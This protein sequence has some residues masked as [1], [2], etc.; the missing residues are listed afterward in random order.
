MRVQFV[1]LHISQIK[2][3]MKLCDI[4][5]PDNNL[6]ISGYLYLINKRNLIGK[7]G[8]NL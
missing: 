7:K 1:Y 3:I 8:N 5:H 4:F 2:G 6:C